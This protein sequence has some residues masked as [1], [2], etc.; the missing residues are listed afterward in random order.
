MFRAFMLAGASVA[1]VALSATAFAQQSGQFGNADDAKAML[2]K[3]IA[4]VKADKVK[5]LEMFNKGEDGGYRDRDIYPFCVNF[6]DGK[7][8]ATQVIQTRG[9]DARTFTDATGRHF[10]QELYDKMTKAKDGEI[11]EHR[12]MFPRPGGTTPVQKE[13]FVMR[14]G[15]MY[16]GVGYYK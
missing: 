9:L 1:F 13:A 14:A 10:G 16:C 11:I 8:V 2:T 4:A 6:S 15:D 12:F 3:A 5:A 7:Q